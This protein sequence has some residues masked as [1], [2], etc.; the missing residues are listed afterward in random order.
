MSTVRARDR[1]TVLQALRAGVVPRTGL[2]FIQVRFQNVPDFI[3]EIDDGFLSS[4]P[5]YPDS[6]G[7]QIHI[8]YI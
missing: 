8:V 3:A 6:T 7:V 2:A 5:E 4:L 1:D